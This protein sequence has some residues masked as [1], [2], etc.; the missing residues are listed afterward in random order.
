MT[1]PNGL[2]RFQNYI[3][4]AFV[5]AS[6]GRTFESLDP[7]TGQPWAAIPEG[8]R[9]GRRPRGRRRPRRASTASGAR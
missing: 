7:Y 3:G 9:R 4:G 2:E 5:D 6:D 1:T 8:T